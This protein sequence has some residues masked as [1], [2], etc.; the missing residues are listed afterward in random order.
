MM[1]HKNDL[2]Y[3]HRLRFPENPFL[4]KYKA[5]YTNP[6]ITVADPVDLTVER[7]N[8]TH[9][10]RASTFLPGVYFDPY[11]DFANV[12]SKIEIFINDE[13]ME[14]P[15]LDQFT[16][17]YQAHNRRFTTSQYCH[18]KYGRDF[19]RFGVNTDREAATVNTLATKAPLLQASQ[20]LNFDDWGATT[21]I[22]SSFGF[23]GHF[24]LSSQSNILAILMDKSVPNGYLRPLTE[25][26]IELYKRDPLDCCIESMSYL[27]TAYMGEANII[28]ANRRPA[29]NLVI[30]DI[31]L[32]YQSLLPNPRDADLYHR[33]S[34]KYYVDVPKFHYSSVEPS[35]RSSQH[36]FRVEAGT[37]AI[38]LGWATNSQMWYNSASGKN[39][40]ARSRFI[41]NCKEVKMR[42]NGKEFLMFQ[43]GLQDLGTS[44]GNTS[45]SCMTYHQYLVRKGLYDRPFEAMFPR[46]LLLSSHDQA[47]ILDLTDYKL[48]QPS[49]LWI[50]ATYSNDLSPKGWNIYCITLQQYLYKQDQNLKFKF[51]PLV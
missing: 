46:G 31:S 2:F 28:G 8:P 39:L 35:T 40:S 33:A 15:D 22:L 42:M 41:P 19:V 44:D 4:V 48:D 47:I 18:E 29:I 21:P 43:D 34:L 17:I 36:N 16:F 45:V 37:K 51:E 14:P 27:N 32:V 26:R 24:P 1:R 5:T 7:Q 9:Y 3:L 23:D 38:I 30:E 10:L 49:D 6:N 20:S 12:F 25:V 50:S 11:L 13:R